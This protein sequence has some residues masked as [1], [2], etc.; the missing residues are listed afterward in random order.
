[1]YLTK[2]DLLKLYSWFDYIHSTNWTYLDVSDRN[3]AN[4]IRQELK[5]NKGG[6]SYDHCKKLL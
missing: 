1:M 5:G 4:K 3:L 2:D 6:L